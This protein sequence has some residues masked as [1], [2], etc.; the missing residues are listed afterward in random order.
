MPYLPNSGLNLN[1]GAG[2]SYTYSSGQPGAYEYIT[3]LAKE[4]T[5]EG[6]QEILKRLLGRLP[7][8]EYQRYM[9]VMYAFQ[10]EAA[11]RLNMPTE[12]FW[13]G[14]N[15]RVYPSGQWEVVNAWNHINE[16]I[17]HCEN[18][19]E[20]FVFLLCGNPPST[21]SPEFASYIRTQCQW[22][23]SAGA[24]GSAAKPVQA[25]QA[26]GIGPL[27]AGAAALYLMFS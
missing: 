9:E 4:G 19:A 25:G 7:S 24:P 14:E 5:K 8:G 11:V 18:A 22:Y 12:V 2:Y 17:N 20:A 6:V 21:G 27:L 1:G 15:I 16:W 26:N 3:E 13:F 23:R 10:Y